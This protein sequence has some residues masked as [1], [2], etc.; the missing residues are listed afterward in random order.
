MKAETGV[1]PYLLFTTGKPETRT[2]NSI[3]AS[4][5]SGRS[6]A[7]TDSSLLPLRVCVSRKLEEEPELE[8]HLGT[9]MWDTSTLNG[10]LATRPNAHFYFDVSAQIQFY[11]F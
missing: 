8:W 7:V 5:M 11:L 10:V 1:W 4:Y 3:K 6:P 2:G 9:L